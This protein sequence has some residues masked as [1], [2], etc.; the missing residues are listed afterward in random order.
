MAESPVITIPTITMEG[1]ANRTHPDPSSD[2]KKFSG[3]Y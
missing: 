2:A 1:D 3:K